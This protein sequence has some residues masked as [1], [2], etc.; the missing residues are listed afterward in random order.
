MP[1]LGEAYTI[2]K[3]GPKEG[4]VEVY[5]VD[6]PGGPGKVYWFEVH[7]PESRAAFY[8]YRNAL[9]KL[10]KL[11]ALSPGVTISKQPG[12]H[13]VYWPEATA[14]PLSP[15]QR[16]KIGA[17]ETALR[18][19]GYSLKDAAL[20]LVEGRPAVLDLPPQLEQAPV[21]APPVPVRRDW[22][23]PAQ[24]ALL[25]FAGALFWL[26]GLNRYFNPPSFTLPDLRGQPAQQALKSLKGRGLWIVFEETSDPKAPA[27]VVLKTLPPPGTRLKP[28]RQVHIIIN[29]PEVK[30]VP[31]LERL[32]L[33]KARAALQAAGLRL[34]EVA[35]AY[36]NA[37]EDTVL[38]TQPPPGTELPAGAPVAVVV[39]AGPAPQET[40]VPDL[41][42]ADPEEAR[43]LLE[44]AGLKTGREEA[45][46]APLPEGQLV[47]QSPQPGAV[48][49]AGTPVVVARAAR[50]E[51][52]L[53]PLPPSEP[54][55]PPE[56]P[57][58]EPPAP[59]SEPAPA[60]AGPGA[61]TVPVKLVLPPELEGQE[62]R[63]T[64]TDAAGTRVLYE[65]P[66]KKG[67]RFEGQVAV[68]GP[69]TFKLYVG[70]H[71]YETWEAK[72]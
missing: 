11:G 47:A 28:G 16:R 54:Q 3:T 32:P 63:L 12:R 24:V 48:V 30:V 49:E 55:S 33:E 34:G 65:G 14:N 2:R 59:P 52:E 70:G 45:I 62:V 5:L 10:E 43:R 18:P 46:P 21:A 71:L 39:S 57:P 51:V 31:A 9:K 4:P 60:P 67:W 38:A 61:S 15:W 69:A 64:V 20:G 66:T 23:K 17:L 27:G 42:D 53:P 13:F 41:K 19:L 37:P 29:A 26:W 22:K 58:G 25:L 1:E 56:A 44:L 8:R 7:D 68:Q 6:G 72:P 50:P 40:L 35:H 36:A